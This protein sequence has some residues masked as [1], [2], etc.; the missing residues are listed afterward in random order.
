MKLRFLFKISLIVISVLLLTIAII[1]WWMH[2]PI[3]SKTSINSTQTIELV[4]PSGSSAIEVGRKLHELG[5][6]TGPELFSLASRIAGVH[7]SL[8]AGVYSL[9]SKTSI[10]SILGRISAGDSLHASITLIEGWTFEQVITEIHKHPHIKKSL[11]TNNISTLSENLASSMGVLTKSMEGWIYPDTYFFQYGASDKQLLKRAVWLQKKSL[12]YAWKN[13]SK[14]SKLN[15]PIEALNLASIIEKETQYDPDRKMVS[16]V[17]HNRLAMNMRLQSDPTIIYGL[18]SK[19]D[20]NLQRKHLKTDSNYNSYMRFGLP[21]TPISNPGRLALLAAVMPAE[22]KALYFVAKGDGTS[23]FS[24]NFQQHKRA[25]NY[26]QR[27][28]GSPPGKKIR[29]E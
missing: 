11:S 15:S 8:K 29:F 2:A 14:Y 9:S 18:G 10:A 7:K 12:D 16:G 26:Y 20:G 5:A 21:P 19:F 1:Y 13:R 27:G 22:T 25:V 23:F 24:Q 4:V 3:F 6:S 17:F 28:I